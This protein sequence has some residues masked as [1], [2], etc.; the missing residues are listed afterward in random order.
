[1]NSDDLKR[2][3]R[4]LF[5]SKKLYYAIPLILSVVIAYYGF[6]LYWYPK[7]QEIDTVEKNMATID[8]VALQ[9][10]V[11]ALRKE[12][13]ELTEKQEK[14]E[15]QVKGMSSELYNNPYDIVMAV[16]RELNGMSFNV[17]DYKLSD[18]QDE[19]TLMMSGSY[20]NLIRFCDFIQSIK[21]QIDIVSYEITLKEDKMI[22][23]MKLKV[24]V[25][26]I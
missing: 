9:N 10:K 5:Q 25:L 14:L 16:V 26:T 15:Q 1:M 22:V 23:E 19:I 6:N 13:K 12:N 2:V 24:G 7:I 18:K 3:F 11:N 21:A 17:Y 4:D 8:P 20:I